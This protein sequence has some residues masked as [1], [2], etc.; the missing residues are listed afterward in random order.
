MITESVRGL[1]GPERQCLQ[2]R[3]AATC[4][5]S[6]LGTTKWALI[7]A[8]CL[9]LLALA[10]AGLIALRPNPTIG[11]IGGGIILFAGMICLYALMAVVSGFFRWRRY[12]RNFVNDVVPIL[13]KALDE[14]QVRSK[15]VTASEVYEIE[16]FEDEGPGYIF[17]L[18]SGKSLLLKGQKYFPEEEGMPWPACQFSLVYSVDGSVWVGLFSTGEELSPSRI[19]EMAEC[20]DDFVWSEREDILDGEPDA[21]ARGIMKK[22]QQSSGGNGG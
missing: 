19:I 5:V 15:E 11:G 14:D 6:G 13:R 4:P 16:E 22:V 21:V 2:Q 12:H 7:W 17:S 8:G 18:G 1:T 9:L 20:T 10:A 3:I